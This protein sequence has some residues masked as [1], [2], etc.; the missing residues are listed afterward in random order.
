MVLVIKRVCRSS[1]CWLGSLSSSAR[2]WR[3]VRIHK[4]EE[5]EVE[6]VE[7]EE[8][9]E[10]GGGCWRRPGGRCW[11]RLAWHFRWNILI[12]FELVVDWGCSN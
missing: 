5:V 7:V 1:T 9:V 11:K 10:V 6:V 8:V 2:M 3:R 12:P 4:V